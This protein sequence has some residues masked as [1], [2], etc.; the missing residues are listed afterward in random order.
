MCWALRFGFRMGVVSIDAFSMCFGIDAKF[1]RR[2]SNSISPYF[3]GENPT[4]LRL[5]CVIARQ[6]LFSPNF[7]RENTA[8]GMP[9]FHSENLAK[10]LVWCAMA[11]RQGF[12]SMYMACIDM[13]LLWWTKALQ[14]IKH[15]DTCRIH[16]ETNV[17]W[18]HGSRQSHHDDRAHNRAW[19]CIYGNRLK[20]IPILQGQELSWL[21]RV[22][23]IATRVNHTKCT[24]THTRASIYIYIHHAQ[25]NH[26]E[27]ESKSNMANI[28]RA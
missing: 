7:R 3:R 15:V 14:R 1:P 13:L 22:T 9:H 24:I 19:I 25:C 28:S 18:W 26:T 6:T 23:H 21:E 2:K 10:L 12:A 20:H 8:M 27:Q 5:K 11:H 16:N 17:T 4:A